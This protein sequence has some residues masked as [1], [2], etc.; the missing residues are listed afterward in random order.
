VGWT[1]GDIPD[2]TGQVAVVTGANRGLGFETVRALAARGAHVVMTARDPAEG[3]SARRSILAEHPAASL[4]VRRLDLASLDAVRHFAAELV[5]D[6]PEIDVL[7]NNAGVMGTPRVETADGFELQFGVNHLGHFALTAFLMPALLRAEA[8]RVVS[9]SSFARLW[10]GRLDPADPHR[11]RRYSAWRA[12]GQSK[13]A[14]LRF[15]LELDRRLVG[16]GARARSL[17]VHPGFTH[18]NLQAEAVRASGGALPQRL[19]HRA[20]VL[21]G[22]TPERGAGAHL[23]AATD[24]GAQGGEL[25]TPRWVA[26][27]PPVRRP[28]TL[29]SRRPSAARRLWDVSERET[30]IVFDVAAM[31]QADRG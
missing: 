17:V 27:G 7:V 1:S 24:P 9:V 26:W 11:T 19:V 21:F 28:V 14:D 13:M 31:V 25:Y 15:A 23:R 22:M 5:A 10:G 3:D 4:T 29:W 20:V 6:H 16:A 2:Q 12:Y 18:T 30:G 8:A